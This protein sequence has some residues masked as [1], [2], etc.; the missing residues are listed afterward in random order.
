MPLQATSGAASYDAF[1]GGVAAVPTYIEDVFS[2]TLYTGNG[3][4]QT[5][6]NGIDLSGKGGMVWVKSRSLTYWHNLVDT[7]RGAQK[8]IFSNTTNAEVNVGVAGLSAFTSSGFSIGTEP[9]YNSPSDTYVSWTFRK[10]PKFFDVVTWTGSNDSGTSIGQGIVP[11]NLGSAPGCVI[12]K[13]V[14]QGATNWIVYHRSLS[15]GYRLLLNT[16]DAQTN[17]GSVSYFS[18]YV[19]GVGWTQ[20]NPDATNI[21]VGYNYQT[22]GNADTMV[23]YLFAHDAG[24]FGLTGTDN[25]ISCGSF[26]TDSVTGI[27][28]VSL[29]YEPQWVLLKRTSSTADWYIADTMRGLSTAE[30]A[31]TLNPN[32]TNAESSAQQAA[33]INATGF[34]ANGPSS[35]TYI[36]IAIRRGPMKV[37]TSG[38]SVFSPITYVGA[39]GAAQNISAGF[40]VDMDIIKIR[41]DNSR[42]PLNHA[43]LMGG[44][45]LSTNATGA[46]QSYSD[47]IVS[48]NNAQNV[49]GLPVTGGGT[50]EINGASTS[51]YIAWAMRRAPSFMDV[52]CYTATQSSST[53]T[54]YHN[55]GVVPE[56][57]I[58][59]ARDSGNG[60]KVYSATL[61]VNQYLQLHT[62]IAAA[63]D[64]GWATVSSTSFFLKAGNGQYVAYLFA[65]CAGVSK[66]GSYTGTGTTKQID[67]GFTGGA[68]FVLIKKTSGTGSWYVWDSAR[69]IVSGNDP[70]LLLNST[71]A[72]VTNTDYIDTYSAGFEI[73]STAP[74]EINENGGSFI[75]FAVS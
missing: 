57:I 53:G 67:C 15:G 70:Y 63:T 22:N 16:T 74:S 33:S 25:V 35:A 56:L 39:N 6:T 8:S 17:S 10:Q 36:Y 40:P 72:E 73:S 58:I 26:T 14:T 37:P 52:V 38:T 21:Y 45:F 46:E 75:F 68:R 42:N 47:N 30:Y 61:G 34:T 49:I 44:V 64:T 20:T 1:G 29:G 69:G 59:K 41:N 43:R 18:K 54:A 7:V 71:A 9:D 60:W 66:V 2:T 51:T 27:G 50:N 32:L 4:T 13:N 31:T 5:I 19:G 62:D 12:I 3:S 11:H 23:A 65:T 24:G 28:T 55:L 48:F